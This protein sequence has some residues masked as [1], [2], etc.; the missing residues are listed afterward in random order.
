MKKLVLFD[1]DGTLIKNFKGHIAALFEAMEKIYGIGIKDKNLNYH[2]MTDQQIMIEILEQN[3]LDQKTIEFKLKECCEEMTKIFNKTLKKEKIFLI[4]GVNN[5]L[6]ELKEKDIL[7]GLVTGNL[8]VIAR[9]K[10]KKVGINSYFK[11]GG[12]GSDDKDRTKLV[13]LA[14]KRAEDNF[15]FN[16]NNNVFLIGDTPKDIKA[17]KEVG[18]KT[19]GVATGIYSKDQLIEAGADFA[20]ENLKNKKEIFRIIAE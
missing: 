3:N 17:G 15:E 16:F 7:I 5:F 9:E 13:K 10:M 8:E 11:I 1:I 19:V 18:I 14:I 20:V 12:F 2:G 4:D 6:N